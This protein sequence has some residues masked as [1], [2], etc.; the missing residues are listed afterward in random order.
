MLRMRRVRNCINAWICVIKNATIVRFEL[1]KG[2]QRNVYICTHMW[3]MKS[4][5]VSVRAREMRATRIRSI[6]S[7][8]SNN[9]ATI[10]TLVLKVPEV[11]WSNVRAETIRGRGFVVF[12]SAIPVTRK[13]CNEKWRDDSKMRV[14]RVNV[15]RLVMCRRAR[16]CLSV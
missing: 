14:L 5:E 6:A 16:S 2:N 15:A 13:T 12:C 7:R 8:S 11:V 1:K 3:G 10:E 4:N 9:I